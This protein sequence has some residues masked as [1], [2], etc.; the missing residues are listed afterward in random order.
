MQ[1]ASDSAVM[2]QKLEQLGQAHIFAAWK[3]GEKDER[4]AACFAQLAA[5]EANYPG[6]IES[7]VAS[8]RKLLLQSQRGENPL[9]GWKP[10]VPEDGYDL[11]PGTE[12]FE[13]YE[14]RGLEEAGAVAFVVPAGGLGER[15]GYQGVKFALP[16]EVSSGAGVLETYCGYISAAQRVAREAAQFA[17]AEAAHESATAAGK[18]ADA[19]AEAA[20]AAAAAVP[21][22]KLPLAIMVSDDTEAAIRALLEAH[23]DFGLK[24]QV[25][26]LKQEK[27]AALGDAQAAFAM[28]DAYTV[29][30]KPH[31]HGDVHFL[32][33]ST[34]LAAQWAASGIKW[35]HFF[36]DT[37]TLYFSN[38]L[39]T[40][41][42]SATHGLAANLVACM[43]KAK[44]AIGAVTKLTHSD[45]RTVV[46]N[47]EYNQ[48]EPLLIDSGI[49]EG[50]SNETSGAMAGYSRFPGN[51][52]QIVLEMGA[53]LATLE[54]TGGAID[55]FINPKYTDETR[56][57]FKSPTRLECMMQ[58]Y[59]KT[60][61]EAQKVGW[62]RYPPAYGYFPCKNDIVSAAALSAKGVPPHSA[63]TSEMAVYHMHATALATL[64]ATLGAPVARTFRGVG[65]DVGAAVVLAP[66][67]APCFTLLAE[68]LPTPAQLTISARS[69]LV[70]R[71][72][73][74]E[75][76]K[77]ALD[78]ALVIE[79]AD[80]G[81]LHIRDLSVTND[82]WE[83][84]E[85]TDEEAN[86]ADEETAIRGYRLVKHSSRVIRVDAGQHII[87]ENGRARKATVVPVRTKSQ[88]R[89]EARQRQ[90]QQPGKGGKGDKAADARHITLQLEVEKEGSSCCRCSIS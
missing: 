16:S 1:G 55:E 85:L 83:F 17:A 86:A 78:G 28:S 84:V 2:Q 14:R 80:G 82:G 5:L 44:E 61:D 37:N 68:K 26:L 57:A 39:A 18:S 59:V 88:M 30:T 87:M 56:S 22:I 40:V 62:T 66:S 69:T 33:H 60:V 89:L 11:A 65:V 46:C 58:D 21:L 63:A 31:G 51:I 10:S 45:G 4:K 77:L 90:Q 35:V 13:T 20:E 43:R 38:Y 75:I 9:K 12:A 74:I 25:T 24:G 79:V 36:Q 29:L 67:F 19:A 73:D 52:N 64:G 42:V 70:V 47:V 53:Y 3:D 34:G 54:R 41:G 7:Y 15:L 6:G 32:L 8:A 81:S 71:G 50:D 49:A 27:V 48:L 72:A 76:D 23:D